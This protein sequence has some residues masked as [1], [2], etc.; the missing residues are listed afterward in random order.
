MTSNSVL[1][2]RGDFDVVVIDVK[3]P[4]G[5]TG[6]AGEAYRK[7]FALM[8]RPTGVRCATTSLLHGSGPR[9]P[10]C[11]EQARLREVLADPGRLSEHAS[12]RRAVRQ[13]PDRASAKIGPCGRG[14]VGDRTYTVPLFRRRKCV[15]LLAIPFAVRGCG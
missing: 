11:T 2:A 9:E 12:A 5:A 3:D 15:R 10:S 7:A 13:L 14:M 1:F 4:D 6:P 8:H